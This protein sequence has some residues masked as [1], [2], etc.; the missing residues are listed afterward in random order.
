MGLSKIFQIINKGHERSIRAKRN[1][2]A[3]FLIKGSSIAISLILVPLTISYVNPSRYGIWLTISS[4]VAW[5]SFFD[6]GLT[7][8]LRNRFA[9]AK[10]KHDASIAQVYVS[11]AYA[12]L[13]IVFVGVWILF[14]VFNPFLNWSSMINAPVELAGELSMLAII[15]F[16]YF[17]FTSVL[18]IVTT[19]LTADQ[20]PA[21]ASVIDLIGQA[22]SLFIIF[23]MV[24]VTE[25]SLINL[26]LAFCVAPLLVFV[27]AN[28]Y[29]FGGKYK[30]YRPVFSKVKFSYAK[31]LFNLGI[32]FFIIQVAGI[33]QFQTANVI[34]SRNFT[35]A[36]VTSYNIVYKYFGML[37]MAFIIFLTPFWSASTE[38]YQKGEIGWIKNSVKRYNQLSILLALGGLVMLIFSE[39]IYRLWL[40]EGKVEIGYTLSAW[41]YL[42]FIATI[43]GGT[44]VYFLNSINALRIQFIASIFSPIVYIFLAVFLIKYL[45]MGV[46]SLFVASLFANFNAFILSPLQYHFV[47]NKNKKGIWIK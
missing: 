24:K 23:I 11:T 19:V 7:Q 46:Y 4:I 5:F 44:Y 15:V 2:L 22:I 28:I 21:L 12:I 32:V 14:L 6:I 31:D 38:A 47:I 8:G 13:G 41:G 30:A 40:G 33:I 26:G 42:Y 20:E 36:D 27:L 9:E 18:R 45:H 34:I 43:Y 16:T 35:P 29:F 10:V 37:S 3:S 39:T 25:G 17:C 1:I